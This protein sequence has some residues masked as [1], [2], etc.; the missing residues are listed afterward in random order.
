M[1]RKNTRRIRK[2]SRKYKKGNLKQ[3]GGNS[4][5]I[6]IFTFMHGPGFFSS[7]G[8]LCKAYMYAKKN[9]YP[10][11]IENNNWQYK[12][13]KGWHDYFTTLKV[14]NNNSSTS[15]STI[16]RYSNDLSTLNNL[17]DYSIREYI[18]IIKEI[19]ILQPSIQDIIDKKKA[20]YGEY[21]S[22]YMRRGDKNHEP[23]TMTTSE[24][25]DATGLKDIDQKI[26][27]Q[28]DDYT[29]VEEL[30]R[31]L[32]KSKILTITLPSQRGSKNADMNN[33]TPEERKTDTEQL[34][35]S[36]GIFLGGTECFSFFNSNI[37]IFHKLSN[38]DKVHV[39]IGNKTA[40]E[41]IDKIYD[42]NYVT[43][44][45]DIFKNIT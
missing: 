8:M 14:Y 23:E 45:Y 32:P 16:E 6:V 7:F 13:N 20:E 31:S 12:Y 30:T 26:F 41:R 18:E 15:T 34:L 29:A 4:N 10:F 36:I 9:N 35:I 11:F 40:R 39:Y 44:L 24:V 25:I 3:K 2:N 42:L 37:S 38:Y 28:T 33:W 21:K 27:V 1:A 22:L 5:K 19:Y 43:P 17:P